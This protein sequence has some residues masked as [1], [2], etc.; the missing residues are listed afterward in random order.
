[1]TARLLRFVSWLVIR[2]TWLVAAA[3]VIL[4]GL[5]YWN[6][7]H[8]RL[9]TDLTDLF[10][11]R[12][13]QWR[14]INEFSQKLGYGNQLF[15]IVEAPSVTEDTPEQMEAMADRLVADMNQS[16]LFAVARCSLSDDELM[17]MLRLFAW[18]F[19]AYAQ[20]EQWDEIKRRLDD[21]QIRQT[22]RQASTGLVT[23]FSTFGTNYFLSDPLG[24]TQVVAKNS[25]LT[26]Y[27]SFDMAWGSGNHFFSK[28]HKALLIIAE[29]RSPAA[30]YQF[31]LQILR[32][33][34][35]DI[36]KLSNSDDF[37]SSPLTVTLAGP[38]VYTEQDR[39]FIQSNIRLVSVVSIVAN[40]VLC[41][42]IYPR[43]PLLILSL[44]PTSLGILWTTG[45]ASTYP[46]EI[47]LIS[48]SFIP[49]ITGLGDDQ[50]V[51]FF[52]RVPQEWA[53]TGTLDAAM[54]NTYETT[55]HSI[56]FC[57]LT[58]ATATAALA[59]SSFKALSEFGFVL[60]VGLLMLLVH[61]L[62]TVPTLMR[63]WWKIAKPKA[64]ENVTFRFLPT[65]ARAS[66]DFVGRR[67][68]FVFILSAAMFLLAVAAL[69]FVKMNRKVEITRGENNPAI[70]GQKRLGEKF[71]IEG[72][73]EI[74]VIKGREEEVLER[75][76]KL[77]DALGALSQQG[78]VKSVFSPSSIVPSLQTQAQRAQELKKIN[79]GH[80]TDVL[81]NALKA[82][83]FRIAPFQA[84]IDRLRELARQ[85]P[86]PL[87]LERADQF[88]PRGLLDN[89]IRKTG[90][91]EYLAAIAFYP[92]DP[93]ATDVIPDSTLHAWQQK[94]GDFA[95]FSFNKVNRDLQAQILHD[96]RRAM[97]LTTGGITL[98]VFLIFRSVR[99][100][101]L[102][103]SPI[104]FAIVVTFGVLVLF[105]HQFS[106]MAITALPLIVGIGIDNGIH[107]VQRYLQNEVSIVDIA[108]ASGPALIQSSLTTLI[109]FGALLVS[110]FQPLAE[111]GLVTSIGVA[112]ALGAALWMVPAI[113]LVFG[114][115]RGEPAKS[116][117]STGR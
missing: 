77:T 22:V 75:T 56:L 43:V 52:N 16:G 15:A 110:S 68:R 5:L 1:M 69:P 113:I 83:G 67:S 89:S 87:T 80:A 109:G 35:E 14:T 85:G 70:A 73:P 17:G 106:F 10:G 103:L 44:L 38:Y 96:S 76:E 90:E 40:L 36:G 31:A 100:T 55:G 60:T 45:I 47:N 84:A 2:H 74:F 97:L 9:G 18:N 108:K 99:I 33:T 66:V 28:D 88:L 63:A 49:I 12:D 19:P 8:L 50:V 24:M 107:L 34:R 59:T 25:G 11:D 42:L 82:N 98:I 61:T 26:E 27:A 23:P 21:Q 95:Q 62:F 29:P 116:D 51:H 3:I 94:F 57:I 112:L 58:M 114:P 101:L 13:P 105:G 78:I 93:D 111:M 71:G 72:S 79:L 54:Q 7:R 64:P 53:R 20:P 102:V 4:T 91:N 39:K 92:R 104:V 37:K 86:Q 117:V 65:V 46:G 6:T 81:E 41:L 30:D 32:W 115:R 48:L